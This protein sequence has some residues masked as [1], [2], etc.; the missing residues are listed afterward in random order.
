MLLE[1]LENPTALEIFTKEPTLDEIFL[2]KLLFEAEGPTITI[3]MQ[4]SE[5][6]DRAPAKWLRR[7][8]NAVAIELQALAVNRV[9]LKGWSVDNVARISL[10]KAPDSTIRVSA[11]GSATDFEFN[12][13]WLRVN[14]V[15]P[16]LR[17]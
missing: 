5:V 1:L 12:C 2:S 7:E 15:T 16:Y 17:V 6:P 14:G 4:V 9:E 8:Y 13:G 10:T 3:T 11:T